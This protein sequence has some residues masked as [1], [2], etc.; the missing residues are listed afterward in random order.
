M[1]SLTVEELLAR[2]SVLPPE[3][4]RQIVRQIDQCRRLLGTRA[5]MDAVQQHLK[6]QGISVIQAMFITTRLL[7]N[8]HPN[9]LRAARKIV[10]SSPARR[11]SA[12]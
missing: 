11:R 9:K 10:E 7:G 5:G 4:A 12:P 3:Q 8:D 6:D 2:V 1:P